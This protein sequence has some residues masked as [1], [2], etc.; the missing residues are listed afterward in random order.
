LTPRDVGVGS[1]NP[2]L[3]IKRVWVPNPYIIKRVWVP[4]PY[5]IKRVWGPNPYIIK[6][7]WVP[8]PYIIK[9]IWGP[10][11]YI[12]GEIDLLIHLRDIF[13]GFPRQCYDSTITR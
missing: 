4:N 6:R 1:P 13:Q 11:P 2:P 9:R 5:I 8:N 7:I 10:N 12:R 3:R